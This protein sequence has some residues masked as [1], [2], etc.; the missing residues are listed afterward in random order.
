MSIDYQCAL[1]IGG[2][3]GVGRELAVSLASKGVRTIAVG[4]NEDRLGRLKAEHSGIETVA[5][6]AGQDGVAEKLL[7]EFAP[8]LL[9]LVGGERPKMAPVNEMDWKEFSATWN[10]DTKVAFEFTKAAINLPLP[11][12]A[13]FISFSSGAALGGSPLSGGYAG[14]KRMQHFLV[15]YGQREAERLG[16]GLRFMC[17]IPKQLMAGTDIGA[18]ASSAYA[19]AAGIEVEKFMG[20]WEKPLSAEVASAHII[21]LL[22]NKPENGSSAFAI[23]GTSVE[24]L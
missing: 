13:T 2:S 10:N 22:D 16:L 15:N 8:D 17:V 18:Q 5:M 4:R 11:E 19:Q 1:I 12:G 14:A 9:V 7:D 6:D 23:T 3:S 20:Q 24:A 21:D